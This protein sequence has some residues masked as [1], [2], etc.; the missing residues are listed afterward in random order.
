MVVQEVVDAVLGV[1]FRAHAG[2]VA[3]LVAPWLPAWTAIGLTG[4]S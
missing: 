1:H 2:S 3:R 4:A